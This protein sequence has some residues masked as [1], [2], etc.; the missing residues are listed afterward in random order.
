MLDT[1]L[2]ISKVK[3]EIIEK[4]VSE[5]VSNCSTDEERFILENEF[6]TK[7]KNNTLIT[8][9]DEHETNINSQSINK[10]MNELYIDL[11]TSFSVVNS[12][13]ELISKHDSMSISYINSIKTKI[14][15]IKDKLESCRYSTSFKQM[16]K[17]IIERFRNSNNFDKSRNLQKDRY[18]QWIL[19]KCYVNFD[20]KEN[21]LTLPFLKRDNMLRYDN[22]VST[23]CLNYSFQL[24]EGF[25]Q[26]YNNKTSLENAI[27]G[28]PTSFWSD[29][30]LS[31]APLSV[32]F[33]NSKPQVIYVRDNYFYG[34]DSGAVCDLELNFESINKINE[35]NLVPFTKYPIDIVAIRYKMTDDED[36][37]LIELVTPDNKDKTLKSVFTR[38]K[39]TFRFPDIICKRIYILFTQKHYIR[40]TYVY[41]PTEIS[42]SLLWFNN[43]NDRKEKVTK[44][45][46]KPVY[47]DRELANSLWQQMNDRILS[48]S[49]DELLSIIVGNDKLNHKVLK[50]EYNYGL[51]DIGCYNN[52]FDRTG[53]YISK[54]V[55]LNSNIKSIHIVTDELHPKNSFGKTV[56]DIE[57]YITASDNP[58]TKDW[59]PIFPMNK[60]IIE[61]ELLFITGSTRAYFRFEAETIYK[62]MK[63]GEE[64]PLNSEEFYIHKNPKTGF[65]YCIQIFNYDYNAVYSISYKPVAGSDSVD[66]SSKL[67]TTI[68][69]FNG[70]NTS[71]FELKYRPFTESTVDYC[72]VKVVDISTNNINC[73]IETLNVT[74]I[75]EKGNSYKNFNNLDDKLQFYIFENSIYFN[76]EIES[77]YII[78]ISYK[79]L[80]SKIKIKALFRRNT[81]KDVWLTPALKEIKYMIDTF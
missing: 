21:T 4:V 57:Y 16:S 19:E 62:V 15:Q 68:E 11:L 72:D 34:I 32:S 53:I 55:N 80:V 77:K 17:F 3:D 2:N 58:D 9:L 70:K 20:E 40:E 5:I 71:I 45:V 78:D 65:F 51:Y 69:S 59:I 24:G 43:K 23:A 12:M 76:K 64:I 37:A 50:Y 8:S 33:E 25:M 52:H 75:S 29:T 10:T 42:K 36:E 48:Y 67:E 22:R 74:D 47:Y 63:D 49:Y 66:F 13:T 81:V 39:V 56:T 7:I 73:E 38:D 1:T 27:D 61:S 30:I 14:N 46:F 31:D 6:K 35:I 60:D 54:P 18:G 44:A 28:N 26:S 79:H 41:N